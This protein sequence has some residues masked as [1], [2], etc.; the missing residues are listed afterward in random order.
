MPDMWIDVDSTVTKIPINIMSLIDDGD[1][2]TRETAI[3]YNESGMDLVWNFVTTNGAMTQTAVTPTTGGGDY[4]W[5]NQGDGMYSIGIPASGGAS[6]NNDTEGF[7]WFSGVCDGVLPWR[8]PIIGFRAAGINNILIDNAYSATRGLSGTALPDAAA[9]AAGGLPVSDA[10]GLDLDTQLANTDEITAARM[11]ALTDWIDG[12][13]LDLIIDDILG[14]TG[15]TLPANQTLIYDRIGAPAGAD[16]AADI[17]AL[18]TKIGTN[19]DAAGT[20]TVFAR[21]M[22]IVDSYLADG[23]IGLAQIESLVDDLETRLTSAR[24]GYLDNLNG[25]TAQSGDSFTRIGSNGVG[26]TSL[27]WNAAWDAEVQSEVQDAIEANHLDHLLAVDYNPASKPGAATALLNEMVEDDG[28]VTRFTANALE[29]A[30]SGTGGDATEANQTT[31][32]THL[33]ELKGSGFIESTDSNEAIRDRGDVA[34]GGASSFVGLQGGLLLNFRINEKDGSYVYDRLHSDYKGKLDSDITFVEGMQG[35]ALNFSGVGSVEVFKNF[36]EVRYSRNPVA[37]SGPSEGYDK[38]GIYDPSLLVVGDELWMYCSEVGDDGHI[39]EALWISGDDGLTFD[40]YGVVLDV[41]EVGEWDDW[42]AH[43]VDV[44]YDSDDSTYKM[45]YNGNLLPD[46][47]GKIGY[48][49][50]PDGKVWTKY[51]GNPVFDVDVPGSWDDAGVNYPTVIKEGGIFYM[52]Y[53]GYNSVPQYNGM[54]LA[55]SPD[56]ITWTREA[57]NPVL[58]S[59]TSHKYTVTKQNNIYWVIFQADHLYKRL[60]MGYSSDRITWT[61]VYHPVIDV[62]ATGEWDANVIEDADFMFDGSTARIF[63]SGATIKGFDNQ[64]GL[65]TIENLED[66]LEAAE[67][68]NQYPISIACWIKT[69]DTNS[70]AGIIKRGNDSFPYNAYILYLTGGRFKAFYSLDDSNYVDMTPD[71]DDGGIIN[72]GTWHHIIFTVDASGGELFVDLVSQNTVA[73]TGTPGATTANERMQIGEYTNVLTGQIDD[74]RIYDHVLTSDERRGIYMGVAYTQD[75]TLEAIWNLEDTIENQIDIQGV[76]F[77]TDL[78]SNVAIINT[79]NANW[80]KLT[81]S[82]TITINIKDQNTN[83]VVECAVEIWD[84]ANTVF[85]ERKTTDSSGNTSHDIDDG[86]YTVRIHK[87]GYI[88]SDQTLIISEAATVNYTGTTVIIGT[89]ADPDACRVYDYAFEQDDETPV[90]SL[91]AC[92]FITSLPY[93]YDGKLHSG[94]RRDATYDPETGLFYWDIV[95]GATVKFHVKHFGYINKSKVIPALDQARLSDIED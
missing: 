3:A 1:F 79:G 34:W 74:I 43:D 88:F 29:E 55:T 68:L 95:K 48:A 78:H 19:V 18:N 21:L 53:G 38:L 32:I 71:V 76:G 47:Y 69:T 16:V 82:N 52:W 72:D 12:G 9:D 81:G 31:I 92:C 10:G 27:P 33:T 46:N 5:T 56:G 20:T 65:I 35:R 89:P 67:I 57:T 60:Y 64:I 87:A 77:D 94:A 7:G 58:P 66:K 86:T 2:K 63:Y 11:G 91:D 17:D 39:R 40:Y 44:I 26:L 14:D 49:T 59:T 75:N 90:A 83:N 62:G 24:A 51:A 50:S 73:W 80:G 4:D 54:G 36:N 37:S 23:S 84:A 28:G 42:K 15:T 13:R 61:L 93:D 41:G 6:I 70:G 45:W 8:G 25:H 85:Y 30:P 22:Q